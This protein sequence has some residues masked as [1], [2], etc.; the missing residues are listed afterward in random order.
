LP[1]HSLKKDA[2]S[3]G[4]KQPVETSAAPRD[5]QD[6]LI[7]F[8]CNGCGKR[9]KV[10][11]AKIPPAFKTVKCKACGYKIQLPQT[12]VAKATKSQEQTVAHDE[13]AGRPQADDPVK[14]VSPKVSRSGKKKWPAV[15]AVCM[16]MVLALGTAI[17]LNYIQSD[18][19]KSIQPDWLQG[20][21]P[22]AVKEKADAIQLSDREPFLVLNLSAPLI[23]HAFENRLDPAK[24]TAQLQQ[25]MSLI[26]LID[27]KRLNLYLYLEPNNQVLP[28]LIATGTNRQQLEKLLG[29]REP[30]TKYF[31]RQSGGR[32]RLKTEAIRNGETYRLP[33]EPY[34]VNI[35]ERSASLAP[36][37]W[38]RAMRENPQQLGAT[39]VA[40]FAK[41]TGNSEDLAAVAIRLPDDLTQGWEKKIQHHPAVRSSPQVAEVAGMGA[42]IL[43]QL[44]GSLESVDVLAVRFRFTGQNGRT[45]NYAQKFKP[46]ADGESI[47]RRLADA[48]SAANKV[49]GIIG[50]LIQL[51]QDQRY[52]HRLE[53]RDQ[54]LMLELTW[55]KKED[56]ALLSALASATIGQLFAGAVD[57][58][59]S[60]GDVE[61]R[62][63]TEPSIVTTV[64]VDLLKVNV[65]QM[66]KDNLFPGQYWDM[67][68]EPRMTL[69][70]DTLVLP[71]AALS[72]LRY[73]VKAVQSP[74]GKDVSRRD[75]KK[76]EHRIQPGGLYPGN[77][78][79]NVKK[80]TPP[81]DLD[82][83][84]IF[85]KLA[86]PV[87]LEIVEF[88]AE[89]EMGTVKDAGGVRVTLSRLEKD[90][91]KL[92]SSGGK[93][94]HLIAY[95]KTGG[96][97]ASRESVNT[98]TS[99]AT[100]FEGLIDA[101]KV[102]IVREILEYA[103]EVEADLN[104]GK[105]LVLSKGPEIPARMRYNHHPV[106]N[107]A[108][109]SPDNLKNLNVVW[110]EGH[111]RAWN[112]SLSIELPRHSFSGHAD[113]EVHF[114]GRNKPTLLAGNSAQD[115]TSVSFTVD[116]DKLKQANAAFGKV[117]LNLHTNIS[118]LVFVKEDGR[119]PAS[120]SLPSG[121][122]VSVA[123]DK[124]E[125]TFDAGNADVIQTVAYDFRGKRLKQDQYSRSRGGKR[126]IYFWGVPVKF[127]IDVSTKT[128]ERLIP[129]DI[130][131]RPVDRTAYSAFKLAIENQRHVVAAIKSIDRSRRK[132]RSYYGDDLA[133]LYY[134]H[135]GEQNKPLA[136]ISREI[137]HSDPAGQ[138]RFGYDLKPYKGYY[139][140][141]LSGVETNGI[142]KDYHRRAKKSR[143]SWQNGTFTTT[144]LTRHPDLVAIPADAS[145][146]TFFLQWGQ[147]F[148]KPLNGKK[149]EYLPDGY[150]N[151]GWV[152][153]KY[154][155]G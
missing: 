44:T 135:H 67:G 29:Q 107:Y 127:Q 36:A 39:F 154:I 131:R 144:A 65:P 130:E 78:S 149:L 146:P 84:R 64:D 98:A 111:D 114:F 83:A 142:Q 128:I 60:L 23:L 123:F 27:L 139:F 12:A 115:S 68:D 13:R 122:T 104:R 24:K 50:N 106:I 11:R 28:V 132:Y 97:L 47:Y 2:A 102:V 116:K 87:A 70:L 34:D 109:F 112:D 105:P 18:W 32:Y 137:A 73:E 141:V 56:E 151:K 153:A 7:R 94:M 20:W 93:S 53:F 43:S 143:F 31:V 3:A 63:T 89:D 103:F 45:L 82:R 57:L 79:I 113:W 35:A 9:Y 120:Q 19:L 129:F 140:T 37:S 108:D 75:E 85:F 62:Y 69:D 66:I 88:S 48:N 21:W 148:M 92:S 4:A 61:A 25:M 59:P 41:A 10:G 6:E 96:A 38:T 58:S 134:L 46:G 1:V 52:Q 8:T 101:L 95:D 118:R 74:A 124:N 49:D 155:D 22:R 26:K 117:R 91:A 77:I 5:A 55:L 133:G 90:V 54:R 17:H 138:K 125:I 42:A 99:A 76:F 86:L 145:Q 30:F 33:G 110:R 121:G 72:E 71:N 16:L 126:S 80:G 51:F 40:Q 100:R 136:L 119:P 147:V 150:Y 15:L 152:E 14:P 81:E